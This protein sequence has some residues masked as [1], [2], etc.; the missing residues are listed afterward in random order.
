MGW[1][2]GK[3]RLTEEQRAERAQR[4]ERSMYDML[5]PFLHG[6]GKHY[7]CGEVVITTHL[8]DPNATTISRAAMDEHRKT[9]WSTKPEKVAKGG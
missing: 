1:T 6:D 2:K 7:G 4:H 8:L 3:P 5:V 9:C